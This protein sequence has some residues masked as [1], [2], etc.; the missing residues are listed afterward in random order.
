MSDKNYTVS[1]D[2]IIA[3]GVSDAVKNLYG[4]DAPASSI[5]PQQTKREFEG[6]LTIVVFPWVKA[7]RKSPEA[8]GDEIG[9]YLVEHCNA[10]SRY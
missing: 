5:V 6:N 10:V 7:A 2:D 9:R 3:Q 4:V 1:V 8:V